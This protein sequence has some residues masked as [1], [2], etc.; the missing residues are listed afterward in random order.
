MDL[1]LADKAAIVTGGSRGIGKAIALELARE[2]CAVAIVARGLDALTAAAEEIRAETGATVVPISADTGSDAS[3]GAMV[4]QVAARLGR[5]DVLVNSGSAVGSSVAFKLAGITEEAFWEQMNVKVLGYL[6]CIQHVAPHMI[7]RGW[8]RI[9]NISG[10]AARQSLSVIG[11]TRNVAVVAMSKNVAD[12]L[13]KHGIN[14]TV[15]HPGATLT[16]HYAAQMGDLAAQ[17]G[18]T[19]DEAIRQRFASN[20]IRTPIEPRHIAHVVAFLAS[21]RSVAIN[22]DV[23]GVAGGS[24]GAIYY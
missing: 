10:M 22:G 6:R 3:V 5:I 9:I 11:S 4:D 12:E 20:S 17:R 16:E 23:I 13:G 14:V 1:Q 8:G 18:I 19:R 2:G 7:E 24:P 15:V 21:P